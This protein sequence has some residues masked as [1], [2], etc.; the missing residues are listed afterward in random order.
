MPVSGDGESVKLR[1]LLDRTSIEIFAN[2]G[3]SV[4]SSCFLPAA[5][6]MQP[7]FILGRGSATIKSIRINTLESIW[8]GL[9]GTGIPPIR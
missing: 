8:N 5:I 7:K 2:D 4:I 6:D 1:V 3:E 9:R